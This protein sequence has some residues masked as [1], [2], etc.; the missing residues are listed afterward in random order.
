MQKIAILVAAAVLGVGGDAEAACEF[1]GQQY[2]AG[3]TICEC[4]SLKAT[5]LGS[6]GA[7]GV[8]TSRRDLCEGR[9]LG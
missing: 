6:T 4:P 7:Q 9:K 8:I 1:A 3:S 2:S 5:M